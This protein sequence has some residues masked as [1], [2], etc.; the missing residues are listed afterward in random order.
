MPPACPSGAP[1]RQASPRA[2]AP[3]VPDWM[4]SGLCPRGCGPR[5]STVA[6]PGF[7]EDLR[8]GGS[9]EARL[10][11]APTRLQGAEPLHAQHAVVF[12]SPGVAPVRVVSPG[13]RPQ[14]S[15]KGFWNVAN[16]LS[17]TRRGPGAGG[18][19]MA[20]VRALSDRAARR[21]EGEL[22]SGRD[23]MLVAGALAPQ[24]RSLAEVLL[25]GVK[26]AIQ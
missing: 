20:A 1:G 21:A 14:T 9:S 16:R 24:S 8:P 10:P 18:S 2:L 23:A 6:V 22:M 12:N 3:E 13:T 19:S 25:M 17:V 15:V 5:E 7:P 11:G 26:A 4:D